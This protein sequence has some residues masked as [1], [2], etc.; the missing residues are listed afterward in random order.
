MHFGTTVPEGE[1][2]EFVRT[3]VMGHPLDGVHRGHDPVAASLDRGLHQ[4]LRLV[5]TAGRG[6]DRDVRPAGLRFGG[7]GHRDRVPQR[8]SEF[9]SAVV[10]VRTRI[11]VELQ[12][13]VR[14]KLQQQFVEIR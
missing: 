9:S 8:V 6:P 4:I 1:I 12:S 2:R 5:E 10:D 13:P 7:I 3:L 14:P 11:D